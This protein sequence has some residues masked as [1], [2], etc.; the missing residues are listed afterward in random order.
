M[1]P[2]FTAAQKGKAPEVT[3]APAKALPSPGPSQQGRPYP[4]AART[5]NIIFSIDP[6]TARRQEAEV[7]GI[8][9][10]HSSF[11]PLTFC[12]EDLPQQGNIHNDPIIVVAGITDFDVRR[13]L[14]DSG[15]ATDIL[16][17]SAFL[18]MG[19][20]KVN[21]LR[22]GTTL[23]G[24][25]GV[26][27]Q[28]LGFVALPVSFSD[29]N[30]YAMNMMNFAVIRAK[31]GYNAILG[32]TIFNSFRMVISMP[33][34]CAKFPTPSGIITIRGDVRQATQC[35]QIAAQLVVD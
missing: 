19:L 12:Q 22:A 3:G 26:R 18:Q 10:Q 15:S 2:T 1:A 4:P 29:D 31:S 6:A 21:L 9:E 33:H 8:S 14:L 27:V 25:S 35:F 23:L 34:L 32:R 7:D 13:V 24:F 5:I 20:K 16:F 28:P 17:E 30:G 11:I